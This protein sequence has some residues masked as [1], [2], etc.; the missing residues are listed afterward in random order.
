MRDVVLWG[1]LREGN[2]G[3]DE[4]IILKLNFKKYDRR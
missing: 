4:S 2:L 1:E 3:T